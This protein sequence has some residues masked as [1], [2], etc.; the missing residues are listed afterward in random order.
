MTV[1]V[2]RDCGEDVKWAKRSD[3][4]TRWNP[5]LDYIG[6][7]YIIDE[8][9]AAI[10][11]NAYRTH[12]CDPDKMEAWLERCRRVAELKGG[13]LDSLEVRAVKADMDRESVWDV[14]LKVACPACEVAVGVKCHSMALRYRKEDKIVGVLNPHPRRLELAYKE[15]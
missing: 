3:D 2:H 9:G 14:A 7:V 15:M 10:Q 4:D 11:V 1:S 12:N 6:P 8:S 13:D 5:P